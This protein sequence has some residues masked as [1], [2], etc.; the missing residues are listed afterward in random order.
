MSNSDYLMLTPA[1]VFEA[2]LRANPT[3]Q[4][5][6]L[7]DIL[8]DKVSI[9]VGQ[10]LTKYSH[11]WLDEFAEQ[12]LVERLPQR[13]V[14]SNMA[15]DEFLPYV[16]ASLSGS[17]RAAIASNEGF[18]LAKIGYTQE[19]ADRL[20]VAAADFFDFVMRQEQRGLDISGRA[21]SLFGQVDLLMPEVS[22]VFLWIDGMGYVLILDSEPLTNNR[23]FVEL[24]WAIKTSGLKFVDLQ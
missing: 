4:Q 9:K 11:E 15:L 8:S 22:F 17:R 19:E 24:V 1:G 16:V 10:W 20:C 3:P 6:A 12:G 7:Q 14:A 18:C 5:L 2:F 13:L 23:A 21:L